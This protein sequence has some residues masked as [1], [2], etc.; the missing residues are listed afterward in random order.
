MLAACASAV[1]A[2]DDE[3]PPERAAAR[4]LNIDF[5]Q[6]FHDGGTI[7]DVI[8]GLSLAMMALVFEHLLTIRRG[9]MIPRGLPEEAHR[10]ITAGQY[11]GAEEACRSRPSLLAY[12]LLAGLKEVNLGYHAVEKAM[13]DAAAEQSARLLRKIEYLSVIGSVAT[14]LGLLGTIWGMILAFMEFERKANPQISELAPGVYKALVTTLLGL[15]VAIP[16]SVAFAF[17]RNRIDEL[18]RGRSTAVR[19]G[20]RR[21]PRGF[22]PAAPTECSPWA[23]E[24]PV[25]RL[26]SQGRAYGLAFHITPLI[27]LVFL[28][29]IFFLVATYFIRHELV[30]PVELPS[31][32]QGRVESDDAPG[33]LIVTITSDGRISSGGKALALDDF[34]LYLQETL[35]RHGPEATEVRIR[36][37][38]MVPYSEVEPLLLKAAELG[39]TRVRFAVL[40][41]R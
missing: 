37:D 14:M 25:M 32:A 3:T 26:P 13:E 1:C 35:S 16:A 15:S 28:L 19:R 10:Q 39:V 22:A 18:R 4:P 17:F 7:G 30:E 9:T 20:P 23:C 8:C 5:V 27:D 40:Q 36:A 21:T 33:R 31:S 41:E 34:Q 12:L 2:G 29:N 11:K 24:E 38:R 6:L